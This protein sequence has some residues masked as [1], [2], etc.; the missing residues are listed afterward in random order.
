MNVCL[1]IRYSLERIKFE[2]NVYF[3]VDK[4]KSKI[5]FMSS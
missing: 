5:K 1:F 2:V 4:N 3:E